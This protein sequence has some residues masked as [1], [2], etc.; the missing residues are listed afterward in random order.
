MT[1]SSRFRIFLDSIGPCYYWSVIQSLL[2][3]VQRVQL[4]LQHAE[5]PSP[6]VAIDC[7]RALSAAHNPALLL[8]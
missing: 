1:R 6:P 2:G 8:S 5:S 4:L 7:D 3:Y